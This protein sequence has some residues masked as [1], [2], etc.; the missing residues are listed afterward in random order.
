MVVEALARCLIKPG[1]QRLAVDAVLQALVLCEDLRLGGRQH[2]IE[3]AQHGHRQ[4]DPLVLRRTIGAA[5]QVG[6]LPDQV[7]EIDA[8]G[9]LPSRLLE[10]KLEELML[11]G[12]G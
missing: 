2:A 5:Q 9:H 1:V 12:I 7:C 3:A 6:D 10:P 11:P 4:H 8:V